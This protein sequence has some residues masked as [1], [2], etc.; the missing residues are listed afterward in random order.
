MLG[1]ALRMRGRSTMATVLNRL[2][3]AALLAVFVA[4]LQAQQPLPRASESYGE[5]DTAAVRPKP[6][7]PTDVRARQMLEQVLQYDPE[8]VSARI[9][10]ANLMIARGLRQR[11]LGEY[12]YLRRLAG[13]DPK[14]LR[15][16]VWNY[17]WALFETG[18]ARRAVAEWME[19]EKLHGGHPIWVPTTYAVGLWVA[20]DR[21]LAVQFYRAAVNSNPRRWG[22][23]RGLTEATRAWTPNEK[24]AIEAVY[25]A[26]RQQLAAR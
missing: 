1:H 10:N 16:V 17:G 6:I 5:D 26:W 24:L 21:D 14:K 2:L 4:P 20:G 8:N 11:G 7:D 25:A 18:D 3:A 19:A 9:Q 23:E 15:Q 12:E 22:E 13:Q